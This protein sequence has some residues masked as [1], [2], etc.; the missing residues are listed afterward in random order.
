MEQILASCRPV[1]PEEP[2][3]PL[4]DESLLL[5]VQQRDENALRTL[6]ERYHHL[7]FRIVVRIT[8]DRSIA[9]EVLQDVFQSV[10][11]A[12][13]SFRPGGRVSVWLISIARHRAIDMTRQRGF[14]G[15]SRE[16]PLWDI[17]PGDYKDSIQEQAF[18]RIEGEIVR[19]ALTT[20][21]GVQREVIELAYYG[22][23]TRSTIAA[24]LG[25]PVGTVKTRIRLGLLKLHEALK[26]Y[27]E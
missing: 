14:R 8:A 17:S 4:S 18:A 3:A 24:H 27:H 23:L 6:Y 21:P 5:L 12:S 11:Q 2:H 26:E 9:E 7:L 1:A 13:H 25:Q 16:V 19:R 22:G 15:R 20:L 10:W